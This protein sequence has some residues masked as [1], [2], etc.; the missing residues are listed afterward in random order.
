MPK[1]YELIK[2]INL[3]SLKEG[4]ISIS[5]LDHPYGE[6]SDPVAS[7]GVSRS[8][9]AR[10]PEWQ[11]HIPYQDIDALIAALKEAKEKNDARPA[12]YHP[13]DEL[14]AETGGGS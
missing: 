4:I 6:Y 10:N 8:G 11:V 7:I 13:H 2:T 5:H 12:G 9:D 1:K 14:A 3:S